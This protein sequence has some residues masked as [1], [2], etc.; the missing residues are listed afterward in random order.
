MGFALPVAIG[1]KMGIAHS[2]VWVIDGDGSFQMTLQELATVIQEKL[3]IKIAIINNG[4]LGMVKQWQELFYDKRYVA[5]QLSNP[6]FVSL[7]NAYGIPALRVDHP[8]QV[9]D[10]IKEATGTQGAFLIDFVVDPE[11]KVYPMVPPGS[12]LTEFI[13]EAANEAI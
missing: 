3:D 9:P 7:A 4:N 1:A 5:T 13:V 6:D 2:G 8:A 11:E 12:S 10:A